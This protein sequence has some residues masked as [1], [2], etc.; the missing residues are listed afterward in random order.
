MSKGANGTGT[1]YK[2]KYPSKNFPFRAEIW[3]T[4]FSRPDFVN[5]T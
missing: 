3:I 4:D 1:V 2:P 5:M